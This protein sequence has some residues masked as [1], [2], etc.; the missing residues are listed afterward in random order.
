MLEGAGMKWVIFDRSALR[1]VRT[2]PIPDVPKESEGF[3]SF[4][5]RYRRPDAGP[6]HAIVFLYFL[7]EP[8]NERDGLF[9]RGL[10][11]RVS[12]SGDG[13]AASYDFV[14]DLT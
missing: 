6:D 14:L 1:I 7:G 2:A 9:R 8:S 5:A 12:P 10:L 4:A 13:L 11:M 3:A